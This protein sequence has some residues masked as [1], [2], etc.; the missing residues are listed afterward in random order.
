MVPFSLDVLQEHLLSNQSIFEKISPIAF[1]IV[2]QI[3]SITLLSSLHISRLSFK[4]KA[5]I[6]VKWFHRRLLKNR[7]DVEI[8]LRLAVVKGKEKTGKSELKTILAYVGS[9]Y[10]VD[11][12]KVCGKN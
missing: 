4:Q 8:T 10:A 7:L 9:A 2:V 12:A 11:E 3:D 5:N 1:P 6:D